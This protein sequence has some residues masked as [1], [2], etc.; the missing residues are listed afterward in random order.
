LQ[1][2]FA[3]KMPKITKIWSRLTVIAK[4]KRVFVILK[5]SVYVVD[6]LVWLAHL[7]QNQS[8]NRDKFVQHL[9]QYEWTE[10]LNNRFINNKQHYYYY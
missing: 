8:I 1:I 6:I 9:L 10:A 3:I 7:M 2:S 5:H 4:I